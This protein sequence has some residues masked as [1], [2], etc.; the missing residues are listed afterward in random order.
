MTPSVGN[1]I[2]NA[3]P[4]QNIEVDT[5]VAAT[6]ANKTNPVST[7]DDAVNLRPTKIGRPVSANRLSKVLANVN[8]FESQVDTKIGGSVGEEPAKGITSHRTS[9]RKRG[10]YLQVSASFFFLISLTE[11][12]VRYKRAASQLER[13]YVFYF[14]FSVSS[15]LF[16]SV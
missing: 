6:H 12:G 13:I 15:R 11:T 14:F 10:G 1:E 16:V 7:N 2:D 8:F 9:V 4:A 5:S 3:I